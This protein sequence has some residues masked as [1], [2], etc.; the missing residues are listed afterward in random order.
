VCSVITLY[1][2]IGFVNIISIPAGSFAVII[3]IFL[4]KLSDRLMLEGYNFGGPNR[5]TNSL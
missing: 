2:L 5:T 1:L 3:S 4:I